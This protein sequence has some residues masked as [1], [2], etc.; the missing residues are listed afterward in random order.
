M[1][2]TKINGYF[3]YINDQGELDQEIT[4]VIRMCES[5][6]L[7]NHDRCIVDDVLDDRN[8]GKAINLA[9]I[10][11]RLVQR[12][13]QEEEERRREESEEESEEEEEEEDEEESKEEI[14]GIT[15]RVR[16]CIL[17]PTN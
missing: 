13:L 1:S 5:F 8:N 9:D 6:N 11:N 10:F 12:S 2:F 7:R 3:V 17:A 16:R 14:S 15:A 4:Q